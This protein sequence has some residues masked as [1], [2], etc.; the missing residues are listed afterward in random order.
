MLSPMN[1]VLPNVAFIAAAC[2]LPDPGGHGLALLGDTDWMEA[3]ADLLPALG[4][5]NFSDHPHARSIYTLSSPEAGGKFGGGA[6]DRR[7]RLIQAAAAG[8]GLI[9]L[10]AERDFSP[11]V[12][13]AIPPS[14]RLVSCHC[15][16]ASTAELHRRFRSASAVAAHLYRF[17]TR[18]RQISDGLIPLAFLQDLRRSDVTAFADGAPGRWTRLMAPHF[19]ARIV[20]C[21]LESCADESDALTVQSLVEDYGLPGLRPIK[22][23]F[24]I[25]G[26]RLDGSLSPRL[27]NR[28]YQALSL[29]YLFLP[30]HA[31]S[32]PDLWR[33]VVQPRMFEQL[34]LSLA[35]LTITSPYKETILDVARPGSGV[36]TRARSGNVVFLR[37]GE[38]TADTADCQGVLGPLRARG[39]TV[40]GRTAAVVGC[41]GSGRAI[42][43]A[44]GQAGAAV[45]L[46]NR[47][48]ERGRLAV[49]LLRLPFVPLAGFRPA[50]FDLVV[51]ATPV[52]R[53]GQDAPF[54]VSELRAS[55]VVVDLV[56]GSR[57]TPLAARA[58]EAGLMVIDGREVLLSQ[59]ARQFWLMTGHEMPQALARAT[60]GWAPEETFPRIP[61][62]CPDG[63]EC[64]TLETPLCQQ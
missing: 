24:G 44:L 61:Y 16:P 5:G 21:N 10:E 23:L 15:Q 3:R 46:I 40:R 52:G 6:A 43:A 18:G 53:D 17:V 25:V 51:N 49:R 41:G 26:N 9:T 63:I 42:A 33:Q 39:V 54:E 38:W 55:A 19:G 31:E 57:P 7:H 37:D 60:L 29:P 36:V 34:G 58:R 32:L 47:G 20:H 2:G 8:Y 22:L 13:A 64:G 28:A 14:R 35:G 45:T 12:L 27:H 4:P 50:E 48:W 30:F 59:V 1:S 11:E 56:Y 62:R